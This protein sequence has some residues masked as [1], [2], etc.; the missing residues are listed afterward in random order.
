MSNVINFE[1]MAAFFIISSR[2]Q[3]DLKLKMKIF[4]KNFCALIFVYAYFACYRCAAFFAKANA[5]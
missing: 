5:K 2:C 3:R 4:L 1:I